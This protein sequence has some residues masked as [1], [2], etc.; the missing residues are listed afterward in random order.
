[1]ETIKSQDDVDDHEILSY[2]YK[3]VRVNNVLHIPISH[4]SGDSVGIPVVF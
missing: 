3:V 2:H 4:V 1:M